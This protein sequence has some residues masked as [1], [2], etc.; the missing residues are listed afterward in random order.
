MSK[1]FNPAESAAA[2]SFG[3]LPDEWQADAYVQHLFTDLMAAGVSW[4]AAHDI[5]KY[6]QNYIT[7]QYGGDWDDYFDWSDWRKNYELVNAA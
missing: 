6:L 5:E 4:S 7:T 2:R 3:G 1:P